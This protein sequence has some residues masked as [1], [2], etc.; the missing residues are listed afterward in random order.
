MSEELPMRVDR[1]DHFEVSLDGRNHHGKLR[2]LLPAPGLRFS[3]TDSF[4]RLKDRLGSIAVPQGIV[5]GWV[6]DLV[7]GY[8]GY[9]SLDPVVCRIRRGI[10]SPPSIGFHAHHQ[11]DF[12]V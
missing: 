5:P 10:V 6:L 1:F 8:N 9:A 3:G 7:A 4:Q 12:Y 11:R 2:F